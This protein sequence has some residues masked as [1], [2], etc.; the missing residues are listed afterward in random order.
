MTIQ[1]LRAGAWPRAR[2][3]RRKA[4]RGTQGCSDSRRPWLAAYTG[5]ADD[6]QLASLG[7]MPEDILVLRH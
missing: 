1:F 5:V 4:D 2:P 7:L 3:E 6:E